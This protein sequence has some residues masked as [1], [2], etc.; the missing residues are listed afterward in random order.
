MKFGDAITARVEVLE[1]QRERNRVRLRTGC[2]NQRGEE[3]LT[4]EALVMPARARVEYER[5]APAFGL[6]SLWLL[7]PWAW[8]IQATAAWSMLSLAT[9]PGLLPRRTE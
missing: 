6:A 1:V 9:L 5:P 7:Q 2:V 8:A 4:G 3:V